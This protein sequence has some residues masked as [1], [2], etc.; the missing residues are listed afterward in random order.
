MTHSEFNEIYYKQADEVL[1]NHGF[2]RQNS[3]YVK[4]NDTEFFII[5]K[6][7]KRTLFFGFTFVYCHTFMKNLDGEYPDKIMLPQ[8][9]P[10]VFN[11]SDL[12]KLM[13]DGLNNYRYDYEKINEYVGNGNL[14]I[15]LENMS[16]K[17]ASDFID[18]ILKLAINQGLEFLKELKPEF[19]LYQLKEFGKDLWIEQ[20]WISDIEKYISEKKTFA[21]NV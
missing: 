5:Y 13:R 1:R 12:K 17:D 7:T 18:N 9:S 20:N 19:T 16:E 6:N 14:P 2:W 10:F 11:P 4:Q 21:N 8:V 3:H 15:D